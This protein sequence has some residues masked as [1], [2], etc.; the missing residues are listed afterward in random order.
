MKL[1]PSGA[2]EI[3]TTP[4]GTMNFMLLFAPRA[5]NSELPLPPR[6]DEIKVPRHSG[7]IQAAAPPP[8]GEIVSHIPAGASKLPTQ[9]LRQSDETQPFPPIWN[10]ETQAPTRGKKKFMLRHGPRGGHILNPH[11]AP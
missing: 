1:R 7:S 8:G 6:G 9:S 4:T 3:Q 11:A 5:M 10:D 2:D